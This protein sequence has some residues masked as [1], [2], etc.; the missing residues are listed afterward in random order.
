MADVKREQTAAYR[1][2]LEQVRGEVETQVH[3]LPVYRALAAMARHA[4]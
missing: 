2:K 1:A 4:P 3:A